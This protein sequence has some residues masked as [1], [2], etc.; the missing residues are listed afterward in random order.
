MSSLIDTC[1]VLSPIQQSSVQQCTGVTFQSSLAPRISHCKCIG[2]IVLHSTP[3]TYLIM[4]CL[5]DFDEM[6]CR[7]LFFI[8]HDCL[9]HFKI[10]LLYLFDFMVQ[11][12][13]IIIKIKCD[14]FCDFAV[15]IP[16]AYYA[17]NDSYLHIHDNLAEV[18]V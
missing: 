17:V 5:L 4:D 13:T 2:F 3:Y 9:R 18:G 15:K 8:L 14:Y 16:K 11:I 7:F 1:Q 6:K 10:N 12:S